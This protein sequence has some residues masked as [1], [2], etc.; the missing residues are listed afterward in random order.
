MDTICRNTTAVH[1]PATVADA[2]ESTR[3]FLEALQQPAIA[4]DAADSV[5]LV[6]SE[7]VTNAVRHGGGTYTLHLTAHPDLIEVAVDDPSSQAPRMRTPDLDGAGGGFGWG[8]VND[9]A[10]STNVTH[11]PS[12]GKTV[13]AL[14]PR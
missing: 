4:S 7:L 13:S 5:V 6:V 10:H 3:G 14:L 9:L 8:M 12:G 1:S 2:R 11:R